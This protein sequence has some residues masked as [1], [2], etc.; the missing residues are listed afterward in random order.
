MKYSY[1]S[2]LTKGQNLPALCWD[3]CFEYQL[4]M[5][6][7]FSSSFFHCVYK[8]QLEIIQVD[9]PHHFSSK[10]AK[11]VESN[12]RM[13]LKVE[14][15]NLENRDSQSLSVEWLAFSVIL[16]RWKDEKA[17]IQI[18]LF[19]MNF[20]V[21]HIHFSGKPTRK[22]FRGRELIKSLIYSCPGILPRAHKRSQ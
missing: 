14:Q 3:L 19:E 17:N 22:P 2:P 7:L 20:V 11:S 4:D 1:L 6:P 5:P 18:P 12:G 16:F 15:S 21:K 10:C 9:I 8:Y 13:E